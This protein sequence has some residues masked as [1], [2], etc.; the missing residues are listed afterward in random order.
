M[1]EEFTL[2]V[3]SLI[4]WQ[5]LLEHSFSYYFWFSAIIFLVCANYLKFWIDFHH[6]KGHNCHA[7]IIMEIWV[8]FFSYDLW[9][10]FLFDASKPASIGSYMINDITLLQVMPAYIV[11]PNQILFIWQSFYLHSTSSLE[12]ATITLLA[13]LWFNMVACTVGSV[14]T[15]VLFVIWV[16]RWTLDIL[17]ANH[18]MV[19]CWLNISYLI[20]YV[21]FVLMR[22]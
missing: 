19:S 7:N 11:F 16:S 17:Y 8:L 14:Y 18:S 12:W 4:S 6:L 15:F 5:D 9:R 10:S 20:A 13:S 2:W 22:K 3:N 1:A 21:G